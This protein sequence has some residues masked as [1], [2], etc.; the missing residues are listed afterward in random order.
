MG[1]DGVYRK[2][3]WENWIAKCKTMRLD[4]S[5]RPY[6]KINSKW[7]QDLNISPETIKFLE[8]DFPGGAVGKN[9]PANAEDMGLI[10]GPGRFH[11]LLST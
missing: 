1:K 7:F 3:Y 5:L 9:P 6:S 11:M 2:W 8:E 4:H 10:L